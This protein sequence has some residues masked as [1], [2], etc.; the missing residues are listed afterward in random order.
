MFLYII[1]RQPIMQ[2]GGF[3]LI[4]RFIR[5]VSSTSKDKNEITF[6]V[7]IVFRIP[8]MQKFPL[9]SYFELLKKFL[10]AKA[11]PKGNEKSIVTRIFSA[12]LRY[13][14]HLS[15]NFLRNS[16]ITDRLFYLHIP[17]RSAPHYRVVSNFLKIW[18]LI[19]PERSL[20]SGKK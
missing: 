12:N 15:F 5:L 4:F 20:W 18:S 6:S 19:V 14:L 8:I 13:R 11:Y 17:F 7:S 9:D 3:A 16:W 1:L 10:R 2:F